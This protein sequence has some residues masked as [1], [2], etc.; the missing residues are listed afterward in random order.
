MKLE[1][2]LEFTDGIL[3]PENFNDYA[4]IGLQIQGDGRDINHIVTGV[5][6]TQELIDAAKEVGADAIF[7]HHGWFWKG[8]DPRIVGLRYNRI[9][10]IINA[11]M[12]L[13]SYHLPLDAQPEIGNNVLF[14]QAIGVNVDFT[15]GSDGLICM[16][17]T[18][19]PVSVQ[20]LGHIIEEALNR[21]PLIV[22]NMEKEIHNIA[23]CTGGGQEYIEEAFEAGCDCYISGEISERTTHV[24]KELGIAYFSAGHHATETFGI[25]ALG[26]AISE[27]FGILNTFI[28]CDNPV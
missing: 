16:G 1:E 19:D 2:I 9:A 13:V 24:A 22:G 15:C 8:D 14:G 11:G 12:A 20:D 25:R 5:S 6:A 3:H 10:G 23:W 4:P 27:Q 26:E 21:T 18:D 17:H 7:V 28:D